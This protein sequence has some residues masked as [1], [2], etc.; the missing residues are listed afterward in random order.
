MMRFDLVMLKACKISQSER[1]L[2]MFSQNKKPT[3]GLSYNMKELYAKNKRYQF[4][5]KKKN[6]WYSQSRKWIYKIILVFP[7]VKNWNKMYQNQE[8]HSREHAW[9]REEVQDF[10]D[11]GK[12]ISEK[13]V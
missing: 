3:K 9:Q 5:L 12:K 11:S 10:K 7:S 8:P 13:C 6:H 1:Y 4:R 2:K